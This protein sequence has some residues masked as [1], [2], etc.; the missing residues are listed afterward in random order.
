MHLDLISFLVVEL[1]GLL[2]VLG[3]FTMMRSMRR[4]AGNSEACKA[5]VVEVHREKSV[6][7]SSLF[8]P[9]L[10][11][12]TYDNRVVR[13]KYPLGSA[14][15]NYREGDEVDVIYNRDN[16]E[17]FIIKGNAALSFAIMLFFAGIILMAFGLAKYFG[18]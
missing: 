11:F 13:K 9:V 5:K 3:G 2:A 6:A 15:E 1:L 10:E 8:F 4:T 7:G 17:D 14:Q 12:K 18:H 16:P